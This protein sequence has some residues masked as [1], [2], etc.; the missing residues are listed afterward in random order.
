MLKFL[1]P[2]F[3]S[4]SY[5]SFLHLNLLRFARGI[6]NQMK[7]RGGKT[8]AQFRRCLSEWHHM[9]WLLTVSHAFLFESKSVSLNLLH[10]GHHMPSFVDKN[11]WGWLFP[12]SINA[13][14]HFWGWDGA[15]FGP[16]KSETCHF[17]LRNTNWEIETCDFLLNNFPMRNR[18][19]W[20]PV[21]I[22]KPMM[23]CW[24]IQTH[25]ILLRYSKLWLPIQ[26]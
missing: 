25:G 14:R 5:R 3:R 26:K 18:N 13:S 15:T 6:R 1:L 17:P 16:Q 7:F 4:N 22:Y 23:S 21:E 2:Q 12:F 11:V 8:I 9:W 10:W 24:D 20:F 19:L